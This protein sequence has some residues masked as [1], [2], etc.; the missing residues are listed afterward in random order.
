MIIPLTEL[1]ESEA[2]CNLL[3]S[4]N[5]D[6]HPILARLEVKYRTKVKELLLRRIEH[7]GVG[8]VEVC[9]EEVAAGSSE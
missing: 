2:K 6:Y 9:L 1:R 8:P 5:E 3:V 4:A 7:G